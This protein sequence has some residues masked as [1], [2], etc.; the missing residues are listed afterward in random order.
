MNTKSDRQHRKR[1]L[2]LMADF[3]YG[4]RSAANALAEALRETHGQDCVVE[5][6]NPLDDERAPAF[7]QNDQANYDKLVREMPE[8]YKL[9]YQVSDS[10]VASSLIE[11]AMTLLLFNVLREII[12][13]HQ[14]DVIVC[15]YPIY[16]AI[17]SEIFKLEKRRVPIVTIVTDLGLVH[18]LWFH[19]ASDLYLVPTKTVYDLA[20]EAG[21]S[22]EKVKITGIPVHPDLAKGKQDQT[23]IRSNLGWRTDLFTVLAVGSK[24]VENISDSL[25]TLNHSGLPLQ[26]AIVAGGDDAMY[27]SYQAMEWHVDTHLYNFVTDMAPLMRAADCVLAKAGGLIVTEALA[28]YLPLILVDAIPGQETGNAEFVVNGNAGDLARYPIEVLEVMCHW[29][30]K[31]RE[32]YKERSLN[33]H[34]L[35]R[36]RAAYDVAELVWA[37]A[38]APTE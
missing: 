37:T 8:L 27:K 30:E 15:A 23:S 5:I 31:G 7:F 13:Q 18:K 17:L 2:I 12:Q 33:A 24:R 36:P 16:P 10:T 25:R 3:G 19:P 38:I 1:V 28:C 4:H 22:P 11:S 21:L 32:I 20:V 29:L 14:P 35:G 9:G 6:I 26:L 34:R